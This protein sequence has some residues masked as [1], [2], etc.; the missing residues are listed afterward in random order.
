M[1]HRIKYPDMCIIGDEVG[2]N[3]KQKGDDRIG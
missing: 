3:S 2:G 1:T